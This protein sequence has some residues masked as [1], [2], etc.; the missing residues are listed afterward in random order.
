MSVNQSPSH[1]HNRKLYKD[2]RI[3]QSG[4]GMEV[5]KVPHLQFPF[6]FKRQNVKCNIVQLSGAICIFKYLRYSKRHL[7]IKRS[8]H[9]LHVS[10]RTLFYF[11]T[12]CCA[13]SELAA[14]PQSPPSVSVTS[15][16]FNDSYPVVVIIVI[17]TEER[18]CLM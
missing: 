16:G 4:T 17:L 5:I 18:H 11:R 14:R 6:D 15:R 10:P 13:Y 9:L 8:S 3:L 2:L 12:F 7:K 1:F